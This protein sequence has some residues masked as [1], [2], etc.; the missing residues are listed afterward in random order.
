M[1]KDMK[2]ILDSS[3]V[4][5]HNHLNQNYYIGNKKALFYNFKKLCELHGDNVF[6]YLPVTFHVCKGIDD[7]VYL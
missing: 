3:Q 2:K 4:K 6:K 5:V 1:K 7:P